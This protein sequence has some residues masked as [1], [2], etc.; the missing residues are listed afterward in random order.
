VWGWVFEFLYII[1]AW[2]FEKKTK[3]TDSQGPVVKILKIEVKGQGQG[4]QII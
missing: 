4:F 2:V 3:L 1:W